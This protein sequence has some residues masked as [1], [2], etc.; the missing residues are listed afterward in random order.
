M[1]K[2]VRLSGLAR[3][4]QN[5]MYRLSAYLF[6]WAIALTSVGLI[7]LIFIKPIQNQTEE[8]LRLYPLQFSY[9]QDL[10]RQLLTLQNKELP[11]TQLTE[12][13][14]LALKNKL[15]SQ[16]I[17]LNQFRLEQTA[18]A[19]I[20]VQINAIEFSRWLQ[21][22]EEFRVKNSLYV[23]QATIQRK[24]ELGIVQVRATLLQTP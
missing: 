15:A 24:K 2:I 20:S 1:N 8:R 13:E 6:L 19:K 12:S 17:Q 16:G 3:F 5:P 10:N 14:F 23:T 11:T 4:F 7:W 18:P 22:I 21:L 9:L